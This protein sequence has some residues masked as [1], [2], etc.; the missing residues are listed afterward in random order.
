[1]GLPKF[2][3]YLHHKQHILFHTPSWIGI[4]RFRVTSIKFEGA[5]I[6]YII[7]QMEMNIQLSSYKGIF[8]PLDY[9]TISIV[10]S[11]NHIARFNF[12]YNTPHFY[13]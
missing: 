9:M 3:T 6:D 5:I 7:L 2:E 4:F 1:M 10:T 13:D 12:V 11:L 8:I